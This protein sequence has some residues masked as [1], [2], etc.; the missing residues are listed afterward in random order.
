MKKL[1]IPFFAIALA[2]ALGLACSADISVGPLDTD[3]S[4]T[5]A[6]D[7]APLPTG[8]TP[9]G[10][11]GSVNPQEDGGPNPPP[12]DA[13]PTTPGTFGYAAIAQW[14]ALPQAEKDKVKSFRTIFMHQSVGG[15]LEDGAEAIGFKFEYAE[16][17]GSVG[18]GSKQGP[19]GAL[20]GSNGNPGSKT[21]AM[22]GFVDRS[23]TALRVATLK[24][25]YADVVTSTLSQAQSLYSAM[26]AQV[27]G[28]GVRV[29]HVTPPFV[30]NVPGDN[31]PKMQFRQ[32]LLSTYP[33][34]V[35]FD[36][37]DAESTD[38]SSGTRCERGGSWEICNAV[39]STSGCA[40]RNQGVDSPSGQGH[41]CFQQAQRIV[42]AFLYSIYQAGK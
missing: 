17:S 15:D 42:K 24:F 33:G 31:A 20:A 2:P 23:G 29:V 11:D 3:A 40:S 14:D 41:L 16:A 26:V 21:S 28:K 35:I 27:K 4:A 10:T 38:P 8:T 39:R 18:G 32:W 25:G 34:D 1:T 30:Y 9:P 5:T 22:A 36:L 13:G 12:P 6:P 37:Q 7:G 19:F